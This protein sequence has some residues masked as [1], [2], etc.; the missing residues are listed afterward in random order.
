[1]TYGGEPG[2]KQPL[3]IFHSI[4]FS[5]PP[6]EAFCQIMWDAG[7]Q[8]VF[9][10]RPGFGGSSP[11]P[12]ALMTKQSISSGATAI[13]EAAMLQALVRKLDLRNPIL[14]AVG[15][16]NP[17]CF[18]LVHMVHDWAR[19]IFVNPIFNQDV[20]QVFH[21]AWFRESLKQMISSKSGLRVAESG[22]KFM[23]K[24]DPISFYRT[25]LRKSPGDLTY[26]EAHARD[27]KHAG[28]IALET[29]SE[30]L[31]YD[32]IMC[33]TPDPLLKDGFFGGL[34]AAIVIGS[35]TTPHW[36]NEMRKEAARLDLPLYR[37]TT[38]DIFCA[39]AC[40]NDLLDIIW[41]REPD[42]AVAPFEQRA[43]SALKF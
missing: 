26:V 15:S 20:M 37:T 6:S 40:P 27:Y 12:P 38:G 36:Y 19:V 28:L 21:P 22:M 43:E 1:M 41:E 16:S 24:N 7:L 5:M 39:Y 3:L 2:A 13:A 9:A 14:L 4:E 10:R 11:L 25:I 30:A 8:V 33:L 18:R 31:Y 29:T 23:I 42:K 35:E 34:N 32:T 17:I